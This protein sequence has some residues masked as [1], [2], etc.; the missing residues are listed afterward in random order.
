[1]GAKTAITQKQNK[2]NNNN[3]LLQ[4]GR[5][6]GGGIMIVM[7]LF[8]PLLFVFSFSTRKCLKVNK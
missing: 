5:G 7:P 6:G 4:E 3:L 8:G 2:N 1:L